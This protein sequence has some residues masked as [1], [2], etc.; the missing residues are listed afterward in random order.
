LAI[1]CPLSEV[2]KLAID[3]VKWQQI[4]VGSKR[5]TKKEQQLEN[6]GP[7]IAGQLETFLFRQF[8]LSIFQ[9][10]CRGP[11]GECGVSFSI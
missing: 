1:G 9:F 2:V 3:R 11:C 5:R 10:F 6:A 4:T 8:F 7:E